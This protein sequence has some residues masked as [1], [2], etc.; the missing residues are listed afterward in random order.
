MTSESDEVSLDHLKQFPA[1]VKWRREL[2]MHYQFDAYILNANPISN[3]TIL[4]D[5]LADFRE[6]L[7]KQR[8]TV[9]L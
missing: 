7:Y 1:G 9:E 5:R 3:V 2:L 6:I 8:A 4:Q